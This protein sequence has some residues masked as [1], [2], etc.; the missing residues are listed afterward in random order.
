MF[1]FYRVHR[2]VLLF[3]N[4]RASFYTLRRETSLDNI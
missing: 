4:V 3:L 2:D 1:V